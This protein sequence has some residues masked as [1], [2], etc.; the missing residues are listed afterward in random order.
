MKKTNKDKKH[1][2][3]ELLEMF[4]FAYKESAV[5]FKRMA[6]AAASYEGKINISTWPTLSRISF[7][8]NWN[9]VEQQLPFVMGYLFPKGR[10]PTLVPAEAGVDLQAISRVEDYLRYLMIVVMRIPKVTHLILKDCIRYAVGY[11]LA[12]HEYISVPDVVQK[13][14]YRGSEKL[15]SKVVTGMRGKLSPII[16]YVHPARVIPMPDGSDTD[17]PARADHFVLLTYPEVAFR[18]MFKSDDRYTGNVE[19][20][21]K[22]SR[23]LGCDARVKYQ[24]IM[25]RIAGVEAS[26]RI[27]EDVPVLVPVLIYYGLKEKTYIAA[28]KYIIREV[29]AEGDEVLVSDLI[30]FSAWPDGEQWFPTGPFEAGQS[31]GDGANLWYNGLVDLATYSMNPTRVLNKSMFGNNAVP[32]VGPNQDLEVYGDPSK[33]ARYMDLPPFPQQLFAMGDML[34]DQLGRTGGHPAALDRM[35]PGLV[36]G[37]SNALETMISSSTGRQLLA[38]MMIKTGGMQDM[39]SKILI[40]AQGM[41]GEG[42]DMFISREYDSKKKENTVVEQTI[43]MTD[44]AHAFRVYLDIPAACF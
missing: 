23:N 7:P 42:G 25:A 37:G 40:K 26:G 1:H 27:N 32:P 13:D 15:A 36:R 35:V 38:A 6:T 8:F 34:Q 24:T 2:V 17:G 30:K 3:E 5:H 12:D 39:I 18:E 4:Q 16:R 29:H 9:I 20:I 44:L 22:E 14:L 11:G 31:V 10:W 41:I 33:A 19:E 43:T 21:I 28:G